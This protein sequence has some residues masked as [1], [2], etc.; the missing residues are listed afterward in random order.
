MTPTQQSYQQIQ[1]F[2]EWQQFLKQDWSDH[3]QMTRE[4][5]ELHWPT[6]MGYD[7][8]G[9]LQ[10]IPEWPDLLSHITYDEVLESQDRHRDSAEVEQDQSV[11]YRLGFDKLNSVRGLEPITD[12]LGFDP[13][14]VDVTIHVQSPAQICK[15]H[16]DNI[17]S[18]FQLTPTIR[19]QF[20]DQP[21][22]HRQR[23]PVDTPPLYRMFVALADWDMGHA[24][25]F[26]DHTWS[27]WRRGDV[28]NFEW[29]AVPHGTC[30]FG[31]TPRPMLRITG[32]LQD[33]SVADL[34]NHQW[35][36]SL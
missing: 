8:L 31:W 30:N 33:P 4:V 29:R 27:H 7:Q 6:T 26:G 28:V 18:Y 10:G 34:R 36:I 9:N 12:A 2:G 25:Q 3:Y 16:M 19:E 22:D 20:R 1:T 5:A 32:F 21:F 13:D 11:G 17:S 15:L 35:H 14:T 24:W 23:Q